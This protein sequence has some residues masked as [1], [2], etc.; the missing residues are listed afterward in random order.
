MVCT[1]RW[2]AP[3]RDLAVP[4]GSDAEWTEYVRPATEFDATRH[5]RPSTRTA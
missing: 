5:R 1:N 4:H 3:R 2:L